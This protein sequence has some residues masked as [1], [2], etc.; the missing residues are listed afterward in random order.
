MRIAF[1]ADHRGFRLKEQLKS[2]VAAAGHRVLDLGTN[3]AESVDYPDYAF[4]VAQAVVRRRA[5]R[6]IMVCG[7]GI[8]MCVAANRVRGIRAALCSSAR[9]AVQSRRHNN[10]NVLCL[11]GDMT[12][13]AEA[14]RIVALWLRT[15][16]EAGRH[17]RRIAKLERLR[18]D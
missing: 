9:M 8:G 3:S 5:E 18:R 1:G 4:A 14:K 16:F 7:T 11:G 10:A 6:G 17:R 15:R 12:S 13:A 2:F